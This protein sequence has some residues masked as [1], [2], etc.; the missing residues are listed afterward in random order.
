MTMDTVISAVSGLGAGFL[1]WLMADSKN[2]GR[3][4]AVIERTDTA[5][6]AIEKSAT[7]SQERISALEINMARSDQSRI[8][9]YRVLE[10]LDATKASKEVVDSFRIEITSLRTD[11]DK[12]FD[13]IERLLEQKGKMAE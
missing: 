11:M 13:R 7:H 6:G 1:G 5:I 10:R 2:K 12:R 8:D 9:I 3:V 4:S